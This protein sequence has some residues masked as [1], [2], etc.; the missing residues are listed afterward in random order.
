[1]DARYGIRPLLEFLS[2]KEVPLGAHSMLWYFLGG[3]T[4]FFFLIQIASGVLLLMYYQPGAETSYESIRYIT[5]KVPFGWLIRA[6][7]CWSAH[8]MIVSLVLHMFSTFFLKVYRPPRE[9]TWVSGYLLFATTLCFGFSGYLLPW[10]ELA[11]FATAVGT[12]ALKSVPVIGQWLLQVLRGGTDVTIDTLYR[13]FAFHV[14]VLP[15]AAFAVIG[16]HL[17]FVQRQGMAPPLGHERPARSM[18]FFPD[19]AL[20]DVMLWLGCLLALCALAA[21]L[22]YGPSI[23][24]MEWDLGRKADPLAPAYPGIKPEWYF[25][26]VYQLLKEFPPHVLGIE[27]PQLCLLVVGVLLGVWALVPWLDRQASRNQ[28]SPAF[29]DL[30]VAAILFL[31]FLTLKAWDI[32]G[33]QGTG[34]PVQLAI[35]ARTTSWI[36]VGLYGAI[37]ALRF[38]V[39]R[40]RWFW[41]STAAALHAALHGIA[42]LAYL[43]AGVMAAGS[44]GLLI[45]AFALRGA[46]APGRR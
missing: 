32:G 11:F 2:H 28:P 43:S 8:L 23:P 29:T 30:G 19:F 46:A 31:S 25:L 35:I 44:C 38:L 24:G 13:F 12:D 22:P 1:L 42:G 3:A 9:L 4:L 18:R 34:D 6:V 15:L 39:W 20:R 41:L 26:W 27:G 40:D 21:F 45:G 16:G 37:T 7:H 33:E 17:L 36:T 10:N 14:V 5:T